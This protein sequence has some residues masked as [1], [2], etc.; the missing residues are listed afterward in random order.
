MLGIMPIIFFYQT[1]LTEGFEHKNNTYPGQQQ[2][3]RWNKRFG[4]MSRRK[5]THVKKLREEG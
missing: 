2:K 4:N 5:E 3:S 1:N